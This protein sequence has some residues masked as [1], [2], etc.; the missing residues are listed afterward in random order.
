[1]STAKHPRRSAGNTCRRSF[2]GV[3]P[4]V[5]LNAKGGLSVKRSKAWSGLMLVALFMPGCAESVRQTAK[6]ASVGG[7]V[8]AECEAWAKKQS[9]YDPGMETV[10]GAGLGAVIGAL[11]GA[12][13]GSGY[14][15]MQNK[16]GYEKA[17]SVCMAA[18]GSPVGGATQTAAA[19]PGPPPA[20]AAPVLSQTFGSLKAEVEEVQLVSGDV[21]VTL[22]YTCKYG[23]KLALT[24]PA[25]TR[26]IDNKGKVWPYKTSTGLNP[27]QLKEPK[28]Y[29][30]PRWFTVPGGTTR[31]TAILTFSPPD[32]NAALASGTVFRLSSEQ[33]T[34]GASGS[35]EFEYG[36]TF[37]FVFRSLALPGPPQ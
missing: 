8:H 16:E 29:Y 21:E 9:G 20:P 19:V 5:V 2:S 35:S 33:W 37:T 23:M 15:Y 18:R 27:L 28:D 31:A 1:M 6:P 7:G 12:A 26:L 25:K 14:A 30:N 34:S 11:G 36:Q 22:A 10:K 13:V 4:K 24:D 3:Q 32:A 17:Y